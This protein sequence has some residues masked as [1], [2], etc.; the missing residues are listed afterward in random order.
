MKKPLTILI[1]L[2]LTC[3]VLAPSVLFAQEETVRALPND[4]YMIG[5][6]TRIFVPGDADAPIGSAIVQ[7]VKIR[8][9][10]GLDRG[11]EVNADNNIPSNEPA[12]FPLSVGDKVVVAKN[13]ATDGTH[14]YATDL[15][16]TRPLLMV[17][18]F[19]IILILLLG[20][21]RGLMS[22][23]GLTISVA[24]VM[25]F[26]IPRIAAGGHPALI[27]SLGAVMIMVP[28][29]YLAHGFRARTTIAFVGTLITL[30]LAILMDVSFVHYTK[31]L[32]SSEEAAFYLQLSQG[33][34]ID[35]VGVLIGGIIIGTLGV[36]DDITT[37]Q[38]A[39]I[40]ELH[41][42]NPSLSTFEL[43]RRG[44]S[45]GREHI[46]SL[47][48]TLALAYAG[49]ALPILLLLFINR[50]QPLWVVL[51]NQDIAE[52]IVRTIV[53]SAT[54]ILAVP[55]TTGLAALYFGKRRIRS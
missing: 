40:H 27:A 31:L 12:G 8:I 3:A 24:V 21:L 4:D 6:V 50:I 29:L 23:V 38:S 14:Y 7:R 52:E 47:V 25:F 18:L 16:R 39:V 13:H 36:L 20:R 34:P 1:G 41:E 10:K 48:N 54:L 15:S 32:G 5:T 37:A 44:L 45:V 30:G 51:N 19:F 26:I 53:G 17:T 2:A 9:T 46:A 35:I 11:I 22:L 43:Y 33:A 42:A 55:I 49:A 28:S